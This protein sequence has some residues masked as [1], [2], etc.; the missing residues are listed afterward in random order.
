MKHSTSRR[1]FLRILGAGGI[2]AAAAKALP[3]FGGARGAFG[4]ESRDN[5]PMPKRTLGRTGVEVSMF[6]LGG[7]ATVERADRREQAAE[8]IN[9]A[10]DLGVNY[11]DTSPRYGNGNS[12][13]N[14][15][16]VMASRR[17]EVFLATKTHERHR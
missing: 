2:G 13:R 16:E 4:R 17:N 15:G 9:R 3:F 12:E 7:E 6:S 10:I 11:I 14:I 8:I 5:G 1:R